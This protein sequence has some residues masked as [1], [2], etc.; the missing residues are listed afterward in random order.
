VTRTEFEQFRDLPGKT[1][2]RNIDFTV[3][4]NHPS[5]LA[6]ERIPIKNALGLGANLEIHY[7]RKTEG[8]ILTIIVVEANGP[9]CRLC[10]DNGPH[11]PC[12]RSHKHALMTPR[13]PRDNLKLG[14]EDKSELDGKTMLEVFAVFCGLVKIQH[15]GIFHPPA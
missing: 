15:N 4:K 11:P 7:N 8:K 12:M 1:I 2:D 5:L 13:C 9:I 3:K 6:A 14:V 10:V